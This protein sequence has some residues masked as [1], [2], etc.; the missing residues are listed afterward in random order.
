MVKGTT[1]NKRK[2]IPGYYGRRKGTIQKARKL[3]AHRTGS[4]PGSWRW[5]SKKKPGRSTA[6]AR[7][8]RTPARRNGR[9]K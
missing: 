6:P 8:K 1:K 4:D 3:G 7:G 2:K 9:R 5:E